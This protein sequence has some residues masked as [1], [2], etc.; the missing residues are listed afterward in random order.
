LYQISYVNAAFG[1]TVKTV[2]DIW[3][4]SCTN[5]NL[6]RRADKTRIANDI[7]EAQRPLYEALFESPGVLGVQAGATN[8]GLDKIPLDKLPFKNR[9]RVDAYGVL[10][11]NLDATGKVISDAMGYPSLH[12]AQIIPYVDLFINFGYLDESTRYYSYNR[13]PYMLSALYGLNFRPV[14]FVITASWSAAIGVSKAIYLKNSYFPHQPLSDD[15][16][17]QLKQLLTPEGCDDWY[18][19]RGHHTTVCKLQD[20]LYHFQTEA[21]RLDYVPLLNPGYK[22]TFEQIFEHNAHIYQ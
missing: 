8:I 19:N 6:S 22:Q 18:G 12:P 15:I 14:N 2:F 3:S 5:S 9:V 7:L 11:S 20:P 17:V 10:D 4:D 1:Y 13:S 16:I 21:H